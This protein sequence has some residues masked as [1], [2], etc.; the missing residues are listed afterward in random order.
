MAIVTNALIILSVT[1]L[2]LIMQ[3]R[4]QSLRH[5][6]YPLTKNFSFLDVVRSTSAPIENGCT[7]DAHLGIFIIFFFFARSPDLQK[8][9]ACD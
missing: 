1:V 6:R 7:Y 9:A 5:C 8:T 3:S 4:Q 2:Q